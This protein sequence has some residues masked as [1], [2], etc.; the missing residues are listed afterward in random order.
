MFKT[1]NKCKITKP[2]E[3]FH[4]DKNKKDGHCTLC[5]DCKIEYARQYKTENYEKARASQRNSVKKNKE[6]YLGLSKEWYAKNKEHSNELN[7]KYYYENHDR[8]RILH[9]EYGYKWWREN[10]AKS[11]SY[12]HKRRT[13]EAE[14]NRSFNKQ[15]WESTK[16]YF[17]NKCAYCGEERV[18]TVEHFVPVSKGGSYDI[19]NIIP[20]C[21][22]CNSKKC[23]RDFFDWYAKQE[24]YSKKREQKILKYLNYNKDRTQQLALTI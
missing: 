6:Y 3:S 4:K 22:S 20:I 14:L 18:L 12:R 5:K 1:C 13:R 21:K 9:K 2:I 24:F 7:K 15:I 17:D 10:K 23:N 11:A 16:K 8:M 19:N